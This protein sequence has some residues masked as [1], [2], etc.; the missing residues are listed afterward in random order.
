MVD[1]KKRQAGRDPADFLAAFGCTPN[2]SSLSYSDFVNLHLHTER[3]RIGKLIDTSEAVAIGRGDKT[4]PQSW[5]ELMTDDEAERIA[6]K[7]QE[8]KK[9]FRRET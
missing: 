7:Q 5:I 1:G 2:G 4:I 6:W 3:I 9:Q 8:W